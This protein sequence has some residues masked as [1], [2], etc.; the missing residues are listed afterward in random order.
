[1]AIGD[2]I[3][4]LRVRKGESLQQVA[5]A[6]GASK[7]HIWELESNRSKNP[8][9]DLMQKLAGHFRTTVA[10]LIEE[11][12]GDLNRAEQFFRRNSDKLASLEEDE[13]AIFENLLDKL[14]KKDGER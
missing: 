9:L 8:S 5:D 6:I 13:I 1:M 7:A 3:K 2:R 11:P 4:E 10:Y 12:E 14:A